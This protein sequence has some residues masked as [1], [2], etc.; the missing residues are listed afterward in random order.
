MWTYI[1]NAQYKTRCFPVVWNVRLNINNS[2]CV[3]P[4]VTVFCIDE[5]H[6]VFRFSFLCTVPVRLRLCACALVAARSARRVNGEE[7]EALCL[8]AELWIPRPLRC[9]RVHVVVVFPR[10]KCNIAHAWGCRAA[11]VVTIVFSQPPTSLHL[12]ISLRH[13]RFIL[14]FLGFSLSSWHD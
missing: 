1:L 13:P 6:G 4:T 7:E 5:S 8:P 10:R 12:F 11:N 9:A 14:V 3:R 2:T